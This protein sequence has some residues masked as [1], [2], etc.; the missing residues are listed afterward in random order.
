MKYI[1]TFILISLT[2][3]AIGQKKAEKIDATK[4]LSE[5]IQTKKNGDNMKQVLL[6][7][8]E[9]W[10]AS[11]QDS[12][13]ANEGVINEIETILKDYVIVACT[14][15]DI[16]P[17]GGFNEKE[18]SIEVLASD[19]SKISPTPESELSTEVGNILGI[20]KPAMSQM[21]GQ[22]GQHLKFFIFKNDQHQILNSYEKGKLNFLL[23]GETFT[24]RT[25]FNALVESK[26]CPQDQEK[27][28]GNWDYCPWHGVPLTY[29]N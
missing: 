12:Q 3:T 9:Y 22:L 24:F 29:K 5:I 2:I 4:F 19:Q 28:N 1:L 15:L 27:L 13:F 14:D 7:P 6:M 10:R 8:K 17:F 16:S 21:L 25:P 11:L 26:I 23:N 20:L 18:I